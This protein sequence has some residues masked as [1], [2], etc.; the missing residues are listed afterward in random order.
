MQPSAEEADDQPSR[1]EGQGVW[2]EDITQKKDGV[3]RKEWSGKHKRWDTL[4][5]K[6]QQ[7]NAEISSEV[8]NKIGIPLASDKT[9]LPTT[10][11]MFLGIEFDTQN[12]IMRL[13]NEKLVKLSQ[14]IRDT[15]DSS[16]I[17]LKD[18]QSLLGLLNFACKVVAPGRT[19]CRRLINSTIGVRKS[20]YKIR[21]NKQMKADLEV[22]LDF[23]KQYNGVTV[24][25]DNVW[26]SNEKLELFTDSAGGPKV[27]MG[28]ILQVSGPKAYGQNI[29]LKLES[30]EI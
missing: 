8:C 27:G 3:G 28:F 17:T 15:L 29:G 11:L 2:N 10:L 24:I 6:D 23:L 20:Y 22:W 21:I 19:F 4:G 9:T 12:L 13:P 5:H 30:P 16:K 25:T 1:K 7:K 14:K 18:M 26:V